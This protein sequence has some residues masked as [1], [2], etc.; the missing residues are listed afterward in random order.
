MEEASRVIFSWCPCNLVG[1]VSYRAWAWVVSLATLMTCYSQCTKFCPCHNHT[2]LHLQ[3]FQW[4]QNQ[5]PF[6]LIAWVRVHLSD[7]LENSNN[8]LRVELATTNDSWLTL[9]ECHHNQRMNLYEVM[10][11][12]V[13]IRLI[14]YLA[15]NVTNSQRCF[16]PV[17]HLQQ[18]EF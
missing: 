16:F 17:M 1:S 14:L 4:Q 6:M 18:P 10:I 5:P 8:T 3:E 2:T 15:P 11:L 9:L 13:I 7:K 12:L